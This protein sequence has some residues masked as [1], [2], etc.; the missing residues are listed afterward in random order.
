MKQA[1]NPQNP[2][3]TP[4]GAHQSA[5]K[6]DEKRILWIALCGV[7]VVVAAVVFFNVRGPDMPTSPGQGS[8]TPSMQQGANQTGGPSGDPTTQGSA[9]QRSDTPTPQGREAMGAP[10]GAAPS[11]ESAAS[12]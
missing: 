8:N 1:G 6:R 12:R 7:A 5:S 4:P 11:A 10:V 2:A 3:A 9:P